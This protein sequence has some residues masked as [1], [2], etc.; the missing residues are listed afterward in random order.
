[1]TA[2]KPP[3]WGEEISDAELDSLMT[4]HELSQLVEAPGFR[5]NTGPL[6]HT[7]LPVRMLGGGLVQVRFF[8]RESAPVAVV[9]PVPR[10]PPQRGIDALIWGEE[11]APPRRR[12]LDSEDDSEGPAPRTSR[13]EDSEG[14]DV[15]PWLVKSKRI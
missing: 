2:Y 5:R 3:V 14:D 11:P 8:H 15:H 6:T 9:K 4:A 12:D 10:P 1:M 13:S 7:S